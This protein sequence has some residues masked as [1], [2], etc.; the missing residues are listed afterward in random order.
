M[1]PGFAIKTSRTSAG[2]SSTSALPGKILTFFVLP[3]SPDE[4]FSTPLAAISSITCYLRHGRLSRLSQLTISAW[5]RATP[6]HCR[7]FSDHLHRTKTFLNNKH[8][9]IFPPHFNSGGYKA[10]LLNTNWSYSTPKACEAT[11][12]LSILTL[13]DPA[14]SFVLVSINFRCIGQST[15]S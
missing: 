2:S 12:N 1:V 5:L 7:C 13:V 8:L 11:P 9:R 14:F 10:I 15:Q 4:M 6:Q 3:I